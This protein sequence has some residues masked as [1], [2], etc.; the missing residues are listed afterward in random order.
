MSQSAAQKLER[1]KEQQALTPEQV[2]ALR[3]SFWERVRG[4]AKRARSPRKITLQP[5][6]Y[7]RTAY[8]AEFARRGATRD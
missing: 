3:P 4:W 7:R 6:F 2:S 8:G 1:I 5:Q